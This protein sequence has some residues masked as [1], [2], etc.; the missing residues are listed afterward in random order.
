[1]FVGL[2]WCQLPSFAVYLF[3][4]VLE[5]P[6]FSPSFQKLP[7]NITNVSSVAVAEMLMRQVAVKSQILL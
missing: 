5:P 2:E 7:Q 3:V 1:V 4:V 6:V